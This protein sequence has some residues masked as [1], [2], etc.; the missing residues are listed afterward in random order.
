MIDQLRAAGAIA[1]GISAADKQAQ[2]TKS[3]ATQ[4]E[5]LMIGELLKSA[6]GDS[7]S[8]GWLGAGESDHASSTALDYADQQFAS[9]LAKNGGL[10][11]AN[12]IEHDLSKK[13]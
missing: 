3:A 12:V 10:G 1:G 4:F 6:R 11:L 9:V 2:K 13:P 7:D 5:A 8:S